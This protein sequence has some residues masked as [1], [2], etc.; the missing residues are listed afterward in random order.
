[1]LA[2]A[3]IMALAAAMPEAAP[4][5]WCAAYVGRPFAEKGR[6]PDGYDCWGLARGV[7]ID[8]F[9]VVDLP[10]YGRSYA[11]CNDRETV[12][13]TFEAGVRDGWR[14]VCTPRPGDVII[15]RLAGRPWH[16]GI[17]VAGHWMMHAQVGAGVVLERWTRDLWRNRV[18]GFYR[19]EGQHAG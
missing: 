5:A 16:C 11:H 1:M 12:A 3:E 7:L 19:Y 10:D 9:G 4:P 15:L 14:E 13:R 18:E 8:R 17:I 2:P 6:G